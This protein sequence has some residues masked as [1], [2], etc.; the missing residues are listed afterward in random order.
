MEL[1]RAVPTKKRSV[2][3][4]HLNVV[5]LPNTGKFQAALVPA[6]GLASAA[7]GFVE[8]ALGELPFLGV[9]LRRNEFVRQ[10]PDQTPS[11]S[12]AAAR[13]NYILKKKSLEQVFVAT[14][15]LP[16]FREELRRLVRAPLYYFAPDDGAPE[17]NHKGKDEVV[18]LYTLGKAKHFIGTAGSSF[19]AV[20]RGERTRLG[21]A[22]K[23]S[24]VF[25]SGLTGD[26]AERRCNE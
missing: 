6:A 19:S 11:A 8:R 23:A 18:C 10:H 24:E 12:A 5:G 21:L 4:K 20:V 26:T 16:D 17:L 3:L 25:C 7:R 2:L 9:H 13:L 1:V 15:A 14:D 22:A